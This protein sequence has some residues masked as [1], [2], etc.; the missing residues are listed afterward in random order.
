MTKQIEITPFFQIWIGCLVVNDDKVGDSWCLA[1]KP[2]S[3]CSHIP[4]GAMGLPPLNTAGRGGGAVVD[5]KN[6]YV[7]WTVLHPVPTLTSST[8]QSTSAALDSL[9]LKKI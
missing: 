9:H 6:I 2:A 5:T 4:L 3:R 8:V 7:M 1:L